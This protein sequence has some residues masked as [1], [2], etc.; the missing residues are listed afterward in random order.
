MVCY[1]RGRNSQQTNQ[2]FV[3]GEYSIACFPS[4]F[5]Q[6]LLTLFA[7][8]TRHELKGMILF[9]KS[10][11]VQKRMNRTHLHCFPLRR[12]AELQYKA[13]HHYQMKNLKSCEY[14]TWSPTT[15]KGICATIYLEKASLFL[16]EIDKNFACLGVQSKPVHIPHICCSKA[17]HCS[18][19]PTGSV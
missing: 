3:F 11:G 12:R 13:S 15:V 10:R 9:S 5:E 1:S 8:H 18:R 14:S 7:R 4:L 6:V 19:V 2:Q 17:H 16:G